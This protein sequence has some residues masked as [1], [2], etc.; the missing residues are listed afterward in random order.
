[1]LTPPYRLSMFRMFLM[2]AM[3]TPTLPSLHVTHVSHDAHGF[4]KYHRRA[5]EMRA[6]IQKSYNPFQIAGPLCFNLLLANARLHHH[7]VTPPHLDRVNNRPFHLQV[8]YG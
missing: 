3:L 8:M 4:L 1:M 2:I 6:I 5:K 7:H